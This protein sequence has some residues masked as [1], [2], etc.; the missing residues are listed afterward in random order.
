[1]SATCLNDR[2]LYPVDQL[3]G[4]IRPIFLSSLIEQ[5]RICSKVVHLLRSVAES[6]THT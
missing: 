4:S 6:I 5:F 2:E 1:M 3:R